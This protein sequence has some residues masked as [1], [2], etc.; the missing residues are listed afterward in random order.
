MQ[1]QLLTVHT[2][3]VTGVTCSWHA[4]GSAASVRSEVASASCS[5]SAA[6]CLGPP[7]AAIAIHSS[8]VAIT[9]V[10]G[11]YA[12]CNKHTAEASCLHA[13]LQTFKLY[14][15]VCNR[16]GGALPMNRYLR[17]RS[18]RHVAVQASE[19]L[20]ALV[21]QRKRAGSM[22]LVAGKPPPRLDRTKRRGMQHIKDAVAISVGC[23]ST[24]QP[25]S[26]RLQ[27]CNCAACCA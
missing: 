14:I 6:T 23:T 12:L 20:I 3:L 25:S 15:L 5:R 8:F 13:Y 24:A 10:C 21:S 17:R 11:C 18:F 2:S 26:L 16:F 27:S 7:A 4:A 19:I 1:L 22:I 9:V